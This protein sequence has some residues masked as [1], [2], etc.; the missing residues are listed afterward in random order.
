MNLKIGKNR[1]NIEVKKN[2]TFKCCGTHKYTRGQERE[3]ERHTCMHRQRGHE[4]NCTE[5]ER[6]LEAYATQTYT[7]MHSPCINTCVSMCVHGH[8]HTDGG[9]QNT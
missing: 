5:T 2:N 4:S 9:G 6:E 3:K 7:H 8:V 1:E